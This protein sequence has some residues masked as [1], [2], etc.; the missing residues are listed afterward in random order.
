MRHIMAIG[1]VG[2]LC[3]LLGGGFLLARRSGA[4]LDGGVLL[5]QINRLVAGWEAQNVPESGRLVTIMMND[6]KLSSLV[7]K[8]SKKTSKAESA[9]EA[10]ELPVGGLPSGFGKLT[11][12]FGKTF[13]RGSLSAGDG[14]AFAGSFQASNPVVW[15]HSGF[16]DAD[17]EEMARELMKSIIRANEAG[18]EVNIVTRGIAAAAALKAVTRLEKLAVKGRP[19]TVNKMIA[20][21]MNRPTLKRLDSS[22]F[23]KF[24]RPPN[25]N[26]LANIWRSPSPPSPRK[27]ELYSPN[28]NG[29]WVPLDKL[30]PAIGLYRPQASGPVL[31][32]A[33]LAKFVDILFNRAN[34]MEKVVAYAASIARVNE[35]KLAA[36]QVAQAATEKT[37]A[38]KGAARKVKYEHLA[39]RDLKGRAYDTKVSKPVDSLSAISGGWLA[40][41]RKK[42]K[43]ADQDTNSSG[44][45]QTG[46]WRKHGKAANC[47][48]GNCSWY[49]AMSYCQG[50]LFS[51][52]ELKKLY[53]NRDYGSQKWA[54]ATYWSSEELNQTHARIV[55]SGGA[56]NSYNK[57]YTDPWVWCK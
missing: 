30:L 37:A 12:W 54:G 22:F 45:Q 15:E 46:D 19:V 47:K 55:T 25:L 23:S 57:T 40:E 3:V 29:D 36:E 27:I 20:L 7:D 52:A 13:F 28:Q 34:T 43:T 17:E 41:E 56:V 31:V 1:T 38:E 4:V 50:R 51:V 14:A 53:Q 6:S 16:D 44:Q 2:V 33:D 24:S 5:P 35:A 48:N 26:S 32:D 8:L 10:E 42:A 18:A 49:D 11:S 39:S 21:N 9:V